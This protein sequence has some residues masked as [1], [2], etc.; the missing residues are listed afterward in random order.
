MVESFRIAKW[1]LCLE[2]LPHEFPY[3][4][5]AGQYGQKKKKHFRFSS[6][7]GRLKDD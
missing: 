5:T 2:Y 6:S 3:L 7:L 4:S 1:T